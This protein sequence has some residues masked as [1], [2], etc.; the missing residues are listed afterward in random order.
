MNHLAELRERPI[1]IIIITVVV[2]VLSASTRMQI[3]AERHLVACQTGNRLARPT[4]ARSEP[5][6]TCRARRPAR[7]T[8]GLDAHS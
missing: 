8:P 4:A 5:A 3:V 2:V 1:I 6:P 7:L